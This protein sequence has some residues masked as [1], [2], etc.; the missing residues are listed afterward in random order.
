MDGAT[1]AMDAAGSAAGG[2]PGSFVAALRDYQPLS[3][4]GAAPAVE[5]QVDLKAATATAS[6][7]SSSEVPAQVTAPRHQ[8][9]A[10][11]RNVAPI[12][13]PVRDQRDTVSIASSRYHISRGR[14][15]AEIHVLRSNPSDDAGSFVWWTE[16]LSAKPGDDYVAQDR[17]PQHFAKGKRTARLFV[18][19]VDNAARKTPAEFW[20]VIGE[21]GGSASLG[22]KSR[23]RVRISRP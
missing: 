17:T 9:A 23:A 4:L 16:P 15:F 7:S 22:A 6:Q 10:V 21:P 1:G 20:V 2:A 13:R 5:F 14:R 19:I 12:V 3:A 8:A 11:S 18:R